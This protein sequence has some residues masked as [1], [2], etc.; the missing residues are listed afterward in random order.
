[1]AHWTADGRI[2]VAG[3][4][5]PVAIERPGRRTLMLSF[6]QRPSRASGWSSRTLQDALRSQQPTCSHPPR[7]K[8]AGLLRAALL[9][10]RG[11]PRPPLG[12]LRTAAA[13]LSPSACPGSPTAV[14]LT[15]QE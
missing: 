10:P 6:G 9:G 8:P 13:A 2:A 15:T 11:R 4:A 14:P 7:Q 1:M 5:A 12:G 3:I